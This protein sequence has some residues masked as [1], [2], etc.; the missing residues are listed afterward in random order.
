MYSRRITGE[1]VIKHPNL[2][3]N[4]AR[5][6]FENNATRQV[7]LEALPKFIRS[8]DQWANEI[9]ENDRAKEVLAQLANQ[10]SEINGR[11]PELQRDREQLLR[12]NAELA[13]IGRRL[14]PHVKRL[15][16]LEKQS[17][18]KTHELLEGAERF[19]RKALLNRR[20][21][22]SRI[23]QEVIKAIQREALEPTPSERARAESI[24]ID[25]L[26][27]LVPL[28]ALILG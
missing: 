5:S 17:L 21:D 4:A 19:V 20:Q 7:F 24:P 23:E 10:L 18:D 1:I 12:L 15:Q 8:V 11:L 28:Q 2:I 3:P 22:K 9:Q 26:S 16:T 13:D 14:K 6:D 25:L 27:L